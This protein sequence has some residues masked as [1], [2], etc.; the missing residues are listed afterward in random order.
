[1]KKQ[2]EEE[3]Q[4]PRREQHAETKGD[5]W[6]SKRFDR[7]KKREEGEDVR[8]GSGD[9]KTKRRDDYKK[10]T[11]KDG[12]QGAKPGE[13]RRSSFKRG[14]EEDGNK[15]WGNKSTGGS[16][17]DSFKKKRD[18]DS[19]PKRDRGDYSGKKGR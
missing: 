7:F 19:K 11:G 6:K 14:R 5:D 15:P 9:W 1:L 10:D 16:R 18:D 12:S 13:G 17:R 4:K 8:K 3:S 2:R